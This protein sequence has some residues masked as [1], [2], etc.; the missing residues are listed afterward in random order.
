MPVEGVTIGLRKKA[1]P[2][3]MVAS[4]TTGV[5]GKYEFNCVLPDEYEV[6]IE[7]VADGYSLSTSAISPVDTTNGSVR[8]VDFTVAE[9]RT[10]GGTM[11][12][13]MNYNGSR[14][15]SLP[16]EG[17]T[18]ILKERDG[19]NTLDTLETVTTGSNGKYE[20]TGIIPGTFTVEVETVPDGYNLPAIDLQ[21]HLPT[22]DRIVDVDTTTGS[23]DNA[24]FRTTGTRSISGRVMLQQAGSEVME[25]IHKAFMVLSYK[26]RTF[27]YQETDNTGRYEFTGLTPAGYLLRADL[28]IVYDPDI[29]TTPLKMNPSVIE[30]NVELPDFVTDGVQTYYDRA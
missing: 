2:H 25:P 15:H 16:V 1:S 14:L 6:G 13:L 4:T 11:R 7:A 23:V 18:V 12:S 20:F 22:T 3:E 10:I 29:T 5:D 21:P 28:E 9:T 8:N 30:G 19:T 24:D 27:W 17:A 26:G